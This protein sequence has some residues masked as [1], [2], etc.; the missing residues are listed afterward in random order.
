MMRNRGDD[1]GGGG[2][3]L[4]KR[5]KK[6]IMWKWMKKGQQKEEYNWS[7]LFQQ[8]DR[9]KHLKSHPCK[10]TYTQWRQNN[11]Q[12]IEHISAFI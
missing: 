7:S 12:T 6:K 3:I 2:E 4:K 8:R 11:G 1:D 9:H 5:R 10:H